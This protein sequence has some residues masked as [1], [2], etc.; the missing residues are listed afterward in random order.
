M[1]TAEYKPTT[2]FYLTLYGALG[3]LAGAQGYLAG[4]TLVQVLGWLGYH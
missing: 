2:M 3:A 1:K 4:D